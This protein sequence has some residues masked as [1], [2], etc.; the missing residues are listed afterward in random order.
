M[1]NAGPPSYLAPMTEHA[2]IARDRAVLSVKGVEARDF[3][4]GL[5]TQ[6]VGTV[7]ADRSAYGALLTPQGKVLFDFFLIAD[8]AGPD[9]RILLDVASSRA[10]DL[11]K[12]LKLYKLRARLEIADEPDLAVVLGWGGEPSAP[13][14]F[15]TQRDAACITYVDPRLDGLG[16]RTIVPRADAEALAAQ[17]G[18][19]APHSAYDDHR[20]AL[21]VPESVSDI[22]P[23][24]TFAMDA[25]LD[26]LNGVAYAKGCFVGQ[27][28]ASRMKRK[29]E[30]KKRMLK[31]EFDGP[32]PAIGASVTAGESTLGEVRSVGAETAAQG[33]AMAL[34]RIDR[35]AA[36]IEKGFAPHIG[37]LPV[38]LAEP[39][40]LY[41][42]AD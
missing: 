2:L 11:V 13:A 10:A 31:V 25:N 34:I 18:E 29:G 37:D 12:R 19:I 15:V 35:L 7:T 40:Y 22:I 26:R 9:E 1:D 5:V 42:T 20:L 36:A 16:T 3:L 21:G 6:D 38:S 32:V 8:G 41:A 28:V 4:Q 33:R 17:I 27:E 30:V 14:G 24:Q 39:A 23:E